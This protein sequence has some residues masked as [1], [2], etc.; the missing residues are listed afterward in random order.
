M[1]S[2]G[3]LEKSSDAFSL[4]KRRDFRELWAVEDKAAFVEFAS[5]PVGKAFLAC[6]FALMAIGKIAPL[7]FGA[8][9]ACA[10]LPKMRNGLLAAACLAMALQ[11]D[12]FQ[13]DGVNAALARLPATAMSAPVL[14][15]LSIGVFFLLSGLLLAWA[16]RRGKDCVAARRPVL[17]LLGA[18]AVLTALACM[19]WMQP[20]AQAALWSFL[21]VFNAYFWFLAYA[22]VDQSAREPAPPLFQFG[23]FH[24]FWGSTC[25]PFGKGAAF[26][27][28]VSAKSPE[29]LAVTQ[30]KG[31]KLLVW[32]ALLM[33][34]YDLAAGFVEGYLQLPDT[35]A[36]QAAFW[37]GQPFPVSVS[38][39]AIAWAT[40]RSALKLSIW[41]GQYVAVARFAGFRLPRNTWRPLEARTLVD[42]WN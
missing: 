24:P 2:L 37:R 20:A 41:G 27:R 9:I 14:A 32:T 16:R 6:L 7:P 21:M 15:W 18:N 35:Q 4:P 12:Y 3:A 5:K 29:E 42:F 11:L 33:L 40:V 26:L 38:W 8:A 23:L 30:I 28:R 17:A 22:L 25:T 34:I 10:Y 1:T 36:A 39:G 13:F 19:S 31:L